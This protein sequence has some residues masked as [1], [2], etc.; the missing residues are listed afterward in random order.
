M[1]SNSIPLFSYAMRF[2]SVLFGSV[3]LEYLSFGIRY[4]GILPASVHHCQQNISELEYNDNDK[5][6][7]EHFKRS[8]GLDYESL[9]KKKPATSDSKSSTTTNI[10]TKIFPKIN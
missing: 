8:L 6:L 3:R 7:D 4:F 10:K 1:E 5:L 9:F 2:G